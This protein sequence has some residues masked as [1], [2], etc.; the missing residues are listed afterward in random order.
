MGTGRYLDSPQVDNG[1]SW[2]FRTT[3]GS[4]AWVSA[5][6]DV[7]TSSVYSQSFAYS[8]PIDV[9]VLVTDTIHTWYSASKPNDGFL[10]RLTSS[11]EDSN[12]LNI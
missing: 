4:G 10:V 12:N 9:N 8:N 7:Y 5:G 3:S 2:N 1:C 11:I 6:G